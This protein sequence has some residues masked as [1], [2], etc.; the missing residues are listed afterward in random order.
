MAGRLDGKVALITGVAHGQGRAH[1]IRLASEGAN[2]VGLD[3]C[4]PIDNLPYPIGTEEELAETV[5][6]V[7]ATGQK[8]IGVKG[9]VRNFDDLAK[10]AQTAVDTFGGLD[11]VSANAGICIPS[12]WDATTPQIW[13]DHMD[14]NINGVWNTIRACAPHL[15]ERGGGSIIATSS[16]AGRKMQPW[17]IHY[18]ATKHAVVGIV[19]GFAAELGRHKIRVNAVHP[20]GVA[21]AMASGGMIDAMGAAG[22]ETQ[23]LAAMGS[24]FLP[25]WVAQ[26]EE[27]SAV[28]A[29]LASD[30][31]GWIT[32]ESIS[33]D[34]GQQHF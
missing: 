34:G 31:S 32:A 29:F 21:T 19:R 17:M 12:A 23:N 20:G 14:I 11:I 26:P 7:E 2:I 6:L 22:A 25:Q 1:A 9:D 3:I 10:L 5:R 24:P 18:T 28:V 27:I 16:Y 33:V 30:E 13:Q 4:E 8:M 15:I